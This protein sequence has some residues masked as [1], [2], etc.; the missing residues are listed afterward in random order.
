MKKHF[1]SE[2][3]KQKKFIFPLF[4]RARPWHGSIHG[5]R[6]KSLFASFSSEKEDS[7]FLFSISGAAP[8]PNPAHGVSAVIRN[9]NASPRAE[10]AP[11][12]AQSRGRAFARARIRCKI[13]G[14]GLGVES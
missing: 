1:F 4:P 13:V 3:K 14:K 7:S 9:V 6:K 10:Y 11:M 8:H 2:E 12:G 5:R